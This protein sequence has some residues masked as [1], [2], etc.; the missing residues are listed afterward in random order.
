MEGKLLAE[1]IQR[2][3]LEALD[4]TDRGARTHWNRLVVLHETDMPAALAEVG[5]MTNAEEE[6]KLLTPVLPADGGSGH[7]RRRARVPEVV[8]DRVHERAVVSVERDKG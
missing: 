7:R 4:S 5:F 2:N 1:A 8:H 6:A 3:L